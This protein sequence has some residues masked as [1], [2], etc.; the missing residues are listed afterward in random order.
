V[1][2]VE[3]RVDVVDPRVESVPACSP[4]TA[5]LKILLGNSE[6]LLNSLIENMIGE[7]CGNSRPVQAARTDAFDQFVSQAITGKFDLLILIPNNLISSSTQQVTFTP[8]E[9]GAEAI[10]QIKCRQTTPLIAIALF[11]DRLREDSLLRQAGADSV[12]EIPFT[13][14]DL[15]TAVSGLLGISVSVESCP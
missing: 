11:Q 7:L 8:I 5:K 6:G 3:P 12:L 1:N 4:T 14:D 2:A 9:D 10:R 13:C 15:Q